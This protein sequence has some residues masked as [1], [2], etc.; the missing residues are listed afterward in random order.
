MAGFFTAAL[1]AAGKQGEDTITGS[2]LLFDAAFSD[3]VIQ[4]RSL[5]A[6]FLSKTDLR[7]GS[8]FR[9]PGVTGTK[10]VVGVRRILVVEDDV[11]SIGRVP[12][13]KHMAEARED[14]V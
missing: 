11:A 3:I 2:D 6:G 5:V 12:P 9:I 8:R 1:L 10:L 14:H 4:D 7:A 13:Q